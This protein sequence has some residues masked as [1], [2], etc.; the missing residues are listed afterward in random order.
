MS[1]QN[2]YALRSHGP[3]PAPPA[4]PGRMG[5]DGLPRRSPPTGRLWLKRG[6]RPVRRVADRLR[7]VN[8]VKIKKLEEEMEKMKHHW[9]LEMEAR[10]GAWMHEATPDILGEWRENR[11]WAIADRWRLMAVLNGRAMVLGELYDKKVE[12]LKETRE[13]AKKDRKEL[14][15]MIKLSEIWRKWRK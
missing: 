8:L 4:L 14:K 9:T 6:A 15:E 10:P 12:E 13:D 5:R 11:E 2:R 3:V 1:A 7:D